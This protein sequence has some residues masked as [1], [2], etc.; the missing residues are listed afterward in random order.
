M[1]EKRYRYHT[2]NL[3]ENLTE[4]ILEVIVSGKHGY[5]N[6]PDFTREAVRRYLRVLGY[7]T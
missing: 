2:I 4:V 5:T 7:I 3:P 6:I 1:D